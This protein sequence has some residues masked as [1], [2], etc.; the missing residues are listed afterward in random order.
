V[1]AVF[2]FGGPRTTGLI[3]VEASIRLLQPVS[4]EG[5][6]IVVSER[7]LI[8]IAFSD[9]P[10]FR[11][12]LGGAERPVAITG[13]LRLFP[14]LDPADVIIVVDGPTL[15]AL[16]YIETGRIDSAFDAWW[17]AVDEGASDSVAATLET[18]P[19]DSNQIESR[20][21]RT[22]V[23]RTDPVALGTLGALSLGFVAAIVF[24]MVGFVSSV[25]VG[26]RERMT[27]FALLRAIGLSSRQLAGWLLVEN[28]FLVGLSLLGGTLLGFLLSWLILPLITVNREAEQ[29]FPSLIVIIPWQTIFILEA[30]ILLLLL[31]VST[32]MAVVLRQVGLGTALRI[33]EE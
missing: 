14:S 10:R 30:A 20:V 29:V 27:E 18:A 19:F 31:V 1:G 15:D 28:R 26:A 33:G 6:P 11:L 16:Q 8:D 32:I 2:S 7:L 22:R 21:E 24:A 5:V 25:V 17:L 12:L 9:D 23:L 3:P 13:A 4:T